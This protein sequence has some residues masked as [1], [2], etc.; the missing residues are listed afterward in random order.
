MACPGQ[1]DGTLNASGTGEAKAYGDAE[2]AAQAALDADLLTKKLAWEKANACPQ[3][4]A[5]MDH[6]EDLPV[7]TPPAAADGQPKPLKK[8]GYHLG[9]SVTLKETVGIHRTCY[10]KEADQEAGKAARLE[11][12]KKKEDEAA[13]AA[14]KAAEEKK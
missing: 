3:G 10:E 5:F 6:W 13:K 2:K 11:A 4:C 12:T 1:A 14:K 8:F 7:V 9:Y